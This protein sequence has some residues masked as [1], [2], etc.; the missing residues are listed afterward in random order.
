MALDTT[1]GGSSSD[2]FITL[3][4]W[5]T[6]S[7][8]A[9][10]TTAGTDAEK[11]VHLRDAVKY[12]DR[13]YKWVGIQ[14]YQTQT[15]SWPRLTNVTVDGWPID[16]DTIP[17]DI[18]NAQAELAWLIHEGLNPMATV[19]SGSVKIKE[20]AAGSVS[21]KT[22]Y[23]GGGRENPRIVAIEGLVAAYITQGASQVRMQRG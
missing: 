22:E 5:E 11:E 3:A 23:A 6:Y 16:P 17:V 9:G 8:N 18:Q 20:V 7:T 12:L 14:Q 4:A 13:H 15:L 10:W 19:T 1:I 2:S 21:S